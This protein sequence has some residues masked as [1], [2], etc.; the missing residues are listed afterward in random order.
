MVI[1]QTA[2]GVLASDRV[3]ASGGAGG[4]GGAAGAWELGAASTEGR[5]GTEGHAQG[6]QGAHGAQGAPRRRWLP[7]AARAA[8]PA[9]HQHDHVFRKVRTAHCTLLHCLSAWHLSLTLCSP[10]GPRHPQQAHAGEVRQ[11]E[12]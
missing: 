9:D 5:P 11:A 12:R 3:G 1:S 2:H 6:A 7:P 4:A 8:Q 10:A